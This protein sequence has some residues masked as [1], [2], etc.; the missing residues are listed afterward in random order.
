MTPDQRK[1]CK[2]CRAVE[3]EGQAYGADASVDVELHVIEVEH[4][5]DVLLTH[6]REDE[7]AEDGKSDLAA[8]GVSGE[9]EVDE[10]K[11]GMLDDCFDVIRLMAH[12][13]HGGAGVGGNGEVE[14]GGAGAGVVGAAQPEEVAAALEGEVAIDED[15]GAV[16]LEGRNDVIGADVDVVIAEDA[17]A[18]GGFEGGKDF[19]SDAGCF[20]GL[21]EGER[22][23]ADEVACDEDEVRGEAIDL[24]DHVLE[25]VGLGELL[26][27]DVAELD[28]AEVLE[29]VGEI[30]DGEGKA[31]D[32]PLVAR[33]GSGVGSDAEACSCEGGTEEAAAGE[34]KRS[35]LAMRIR[36]AVGGRT[37]MHTP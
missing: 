34:V 36:L 30:A 20:P 22:A 16:G 3:A 28:D 12:Q 35:W 7:R 2:L 8:V 18:L 14:V 26:E 6:G 17:E 5:L 9:H 15:G 29:A 4:A 33:M 37:A 13:D 31:G 27:M 21:A 32:L 11:A 1:F 25:E 24:G 10:R 19:G 23:A